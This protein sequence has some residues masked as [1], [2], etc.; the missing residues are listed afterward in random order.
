M[1]FKTFLI[2][3]FV[4]FLFNGCKDDNPTEPED[5][6]P[7]DVISSISGK[8]SDWIGASNYTIKLTVDPDGKEYFFAGSSSIAQDGSFNMQNLQDVPANY[9]FEPEGDDDITSTNPNLKIADGDL[10][11]FSPADSYVGDVMFANYSPQNSFMTFY[12]YANGESTLTGSFYDE[13]IRITVNITLKKGWNVYYLVYTSAT[14]GKLTSTKPDGGQWYYSQ[15]KSTRK[16]SN[17]LFKR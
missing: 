15:G 8:I 17:P 12:V 7:G 9:L 11:V 16:I 1:K 6:N 14:Q 3:V 5:N 13:G 4:A 2:L 10:Y